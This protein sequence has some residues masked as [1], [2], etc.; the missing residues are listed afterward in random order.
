MITLPVL[1]VLLSGAH[2]FGAAKP[3]MAQENMTEPFKP[4][5]GLGTNSTPPEYVP[6]SD[7]DFQSLNLALNQEWIEL[8]LFHHGLAMFSDADFDAAGLGPEDRYLIQFMAEQ[9]VGHATLISNMLQGRGAKPC[10]YRYPF[11]TVREF[12]DFCQ[13]LTRWGESGVYGFLEHLNSRAAA[14]LL[15]DSITTE[16]RQQ[17]I[18]R[19]FEGLFPMDIWFVPGIPQSMAWTLLQPY[20]ATCPAENPRVGFQIFP[21]LN[22]TN[23]PDATPLYNTSIVGNDTTPAIAR[24]RTIPLSAPG[25][26]VQ[27]S[28]EEPGRPAGYNNSYTTNTTA[29][30][31][32]FALWIS[33]INSTYTPLENITGNTASTTQPGGMVFGEGTAPI[34]N[35]TIFVAIT[36]TDLSVTP[37]NNSMVNKHVV[38]GPAIYQA[39]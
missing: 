6:M 13:K 15:L 23:N 14:T 1:L 11:K 8:D 16:A 2:I 39:G 17:L 10:T 4:S 37:F 30:D 29:G 20:I 27:L 5:G 19:Q 24:N 36:D 26:T 38:A 22:V 31:P 3:V 33:Q 25:R 28:W 18:F 32:K 12:V 21:A 35:G 9:E 34:Y 7:F